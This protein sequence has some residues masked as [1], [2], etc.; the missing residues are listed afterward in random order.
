[1]ELLKKIDGL[2]IAPVSGGADMQNKILAGELP[3]KVLK[4]KTGREHNGWVIPHRWEVKKAE[5]KKDGKLIYDGKKSP[6]GVVGYSQSFRGKLLLSDLQKHLFYNVDHP[7]N[8]V[9][10]CDYFY[11]PHL[12][13]WGFSLPYNL[14]KKLT[15]GDYDID[16]ITTRSSGE[17]KILEYT[18]RG[19]TDKTILFN[20][21]N[22]HAAQLNDGPAGYVIFME[23]LKRIKNIKTKYNYRLIIAPEHIGT[24][25]YLADLPQKEIA[26]FRYCIF[27]EMMGHDN[28]VIALQESFTGASYLDKIAH[29]VLHFFNHVYK[30]DKFRKILGNDETVWEAPGYAIPTISISRCQ[31]YGNCY[32]EYHLDSDNIK[33]IKEDRLEEGVRLILKIIDVFEKDCLLQRKFT[34]LI[35]LSNPKYDLYLTPGSDP[36]YQLDNIE[37]RQKWNYLMDCLPRYFEKNMS[38]LD[39]AIKHDLPFGE[40]YSY[41]LKFKQKNLVDFIDIK[42]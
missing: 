10:H 11:K 1:M 12:A 24:V 8:I 28:P 14:F 40:L 33:I 16:L 18:H 20:A 34:G 21:H 42:Y 22:C 31:E 39:I 6:L 9:Y 19:K 15:K 30:S 26:K 37:I 38:I 29:H 17:M 41:L 23:A 35:A 5:I 36:S 3:F 4:Y 2:R 7:N 27:M 32:D 25:F 13:D